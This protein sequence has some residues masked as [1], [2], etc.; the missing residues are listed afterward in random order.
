MIGKTQVQSKF[1]KVCSAAGQSI[2]GNVH[3]EAPDVTTQT[4]TRDLACSAIRTMPA[5]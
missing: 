4:H 5:T 1:G 3:S 2:R